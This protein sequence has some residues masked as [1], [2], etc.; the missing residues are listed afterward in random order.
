MSWYE[1]IEDNILSYVKTVLNG[2]GYKPRITSILDKTV[3][4]DDGVPKKFPTVYFHS[5]QPAEVGNDLENTDINAIL[6]TIEIQVFSNDYNECQSL[7]S[8]TLDCMKSLRF[9][10]PMLPITS[11]MGDYFSSVAR[12]RRVVGAGDSELITQE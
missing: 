9:N 7:W 11:K 4:D 12:Y 5:L 8:L 10:V 2:K 3:V 6:T 1:Q